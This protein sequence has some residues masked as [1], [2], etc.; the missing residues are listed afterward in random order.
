MAT[1][2]KNVVSTVNKGGRPAM[3]EEERAEKVLKISTL[4]YA[5]LD[6]LRDREGFDNVPTFTRW[7]I[8][9]YIRENQ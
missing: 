5:D 9:K 7:I 2:K 4:D 8:R 1:R 6:A 3:N